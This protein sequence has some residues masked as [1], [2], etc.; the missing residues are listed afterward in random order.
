MKTEVREAAV[1]T[2]AVALAGVL[3]GVLWW[4]LAPRTTARCI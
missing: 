4:W 2:V 3:L 1:V